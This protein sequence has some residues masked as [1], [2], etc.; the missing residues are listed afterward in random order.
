MKGDLIWGIGEIIFGIVILI[1]VIRNYNLK[2]ES[3]TGLSIGFKG[4][5]AGSV[6]IVIGIIQLARYFG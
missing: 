1:L 2:K 5:I 6:F 3:P 4:L